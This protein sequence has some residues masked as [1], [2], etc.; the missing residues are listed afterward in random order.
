M[1]D[2]KKGDVTPLAPGEVVVCVVEQIMPY[3]AFVRIKNGQRAMIHISEL[4]HGFVKKVEDILALGQEVQA[5]VIKID[6]KGRIDLSLK[7]ME[8]PRPAA[9]FGPRNAAANV[10]EDPRDSFEK[11]LS[12]YLKASEAKIADINSKLNSSKA[13]KKRGK[14][15]K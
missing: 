14:P 13:S 12:N 2:E 10:P 15:A 6:E 3:G 1:A 4:S 9:S 11:K 8:A 7:K 5:R